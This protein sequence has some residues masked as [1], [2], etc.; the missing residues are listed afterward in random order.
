MDWKKYLKPCALVLVG[1][2]IGYLIFDNSNFQS[3]V[4]GELWSINRELGGMESS[5][6][7]LTRR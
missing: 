1:Y 4:S 7:I 6:K 5:L 3:Y 2:F